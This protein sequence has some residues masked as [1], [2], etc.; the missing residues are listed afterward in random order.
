MAKKISGITI[1]IDGDTT[2]LAKSLNDVTSQS[3]KLS[4]NLKTVENL[5]KLDPTN[6]ELLAQKQ[7]ILSDSIAKT[8]EK[9]EALKAAQAGVKAQFERGEI[10]TEQYLLFQKELVNTEKRLEN[11][12]EK[13]ADTGDEVEDLGDDTKKTGKEMASA[14]KD[15]SK[16][17]NT[18]KSG[19]VVAAK[20]A[21]AAVAA[22]GTAAVILAKNVVEQFGELEQNL[23]GSEAVFGEYAKNIQK[24][25][26]DAYK[27]LGT[28]QSEYLAAAN[29]MGALL[30][31]SGFTVEQ[32]LGMTEKALQRAADMA[33]VMGVDVSAAMEAVNGAAKGN[34]TMMD[35][36]GVAINDTTLKA[37]AEAKGLGELATTQDK[38]SA[39]MQLFLEKTEQYDGNFAREATQTVS[40]SIG[41]LGAAWQ[42]MIAGLGNS[43]ADIKNLTANV[44]D[45]MSAVVE[46][47]KP[48]IENVVKVLP[49]VIDTVIGTVESMLPTLLPAVSGIISQ[50]L[51]SLV[52]MLPK[53]IPF[54]I[55]AIGTI[56]KALID[57]LPMLVNAAILLVTSL[58]QDIAAAAPQ[59]MPAIIDTVIQIVEMLTNPETLGGL[60]TA[61][62]AIITALAEG[63]I[64][65]IP[66]L[67]E[68]MPIIMDNICQTIAANL[69]KIVYAAQQIIYTL[70]TT[71]LQNL[72]QMISAGGQVVSAVVQGI[73]SLFDNIASTGSQAVST[74]GGGIMSM[75]GQAVTWGKDLID[76]FISGITQKWSALKQSVSNIAQTVRD[77]IGFSEPDKGPLSNFHTYAP[78]MIDLFTQGIDQ[79]AYKIK[80]QFT[81][82]LSG[83]NVAA[84]LTG[85][86]MARSA[87]PA[88]QAASPMQLNVNVN[89]GSIA[90][91]YDVGRMTDVMIGQISQGLEQLKMRQTAA[92]GGA[93]I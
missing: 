3:V 41:L 56:G 58:A 83:L 89:V 37:Y 49:D 25:G 63:I 29:K 92:L 45:A 65:N 13:A 5:L 4:K 26:E 7:K 62:L 32:S 74:F 91:D 12:K 52:S 30:Q 42:S 35:N 93:L 18:L 21:A 79:N 61:A 15:A 71:I 78:D 36:L 82:S 80:D 64:A 14:E 85:V 68:K 34:F 69:P 77:Y 11:L 19:L 66:T 76:N 38:V 27:N 8:S 33:S 86:S 39:A 23:G 44:A 31:G 90:S 88:M 50:L 9:L 47:V 43:E 55:D 1:A 51:D 17:A 10:G 73:V 22:A 40:G 20:A 87:A 60:I 67:C 54:A 46:N 81:K 28:S 48:V 57:H 2:G 24:T 72:P 59:M 6:T 70:A 53:L 75:I 84:N 16:F